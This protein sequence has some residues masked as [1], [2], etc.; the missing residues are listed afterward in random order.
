M[1]QAGWVACC[2]LAFIPAS[3][4]LADRVLLRGE[5]TSL[6]RD[7]GA[8][9][10]F[11]GT[12]L[13]R[14]VLGEAR[15]PEWRI[16]LQDGVRTF[17]VKGELSELKKTRIL[18]TQTKIAPFPGPGR[19]LLW[20]GDRLV[21]SE[22]L[23]WRTS[24]PDL[25]V[26]SYLSAT[27]TA[28]SYAEVRA[29]AAPFLED[30][31]LW[32]RVNSER[33]IANYYF[34]RSKYQE[35]EDAWRR[36]EQR[37]R[38]AGEPI[39]AERYTYARFLPKLLSCDLDGAQEVL[40]LIPE[41][42]LLRVGK[43]WR[44]FAQAQLASA[45][46]DLRTAEEMFESAAAEA[47]RSGEMKYYLDSVIEEASIFAE[48]GRWREAMVSLATLDKVSKRFPQDARTLALI[49]NLAGWIMLNAKQSGAMAL[50]MNRCQKNLIEASEHAKHAGAYDIL[51]H[52]TI[53]LALLYL[54]QGN[55]REARL[56]LERVRSDEVM[57]KS[58][59]GPFA[60]LALAEVELIEGHSAESMV[61][62]QK[63]SDKLATG[64]SSDRELRWRV[65]HMKGNAWA[66]SGA[67]SSAIEAYQKALEILRERS[68]YVPL[69]GGQFH[70]L[71]RRREPAVALIELL[72]AKGRNT[73]AFWIADELHSSVFQALDGAYKS[74]ER[75]VLRLKKGEAVLSLVQKDE[76]TWFAFLVDAGQTDVIL[77]AAPLA[78]LLPRL[79]NYSRLYVVSGGHEA[80]FHLPAAETATGEPLGAKL[81]ISLL[82]Y[83]SLLL[84]S[85]KREGPNLVVADPISNLDAARAE[86]EA[87]AEKIGGGMLVGRRA[88]RSAVRDR[89][90]KAGILHFAGHGVADA[91]RPW[92][93]HLKLSDGTLTL[94]DIL[95]DRPQIGLVVLASCKS[96]SDMEPTR[97]GLPQAFLHVG[98]NV[99]VASIRR[100]GD[101][102]ARRFV[103]QFYHH[104]G[105][106]DPFR[107]FRRVIENS[108]GDEAWKAFR[109]WGAKGGVESAPDKPIRIS[110]SQRT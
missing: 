71:W 25:E 26:Q 105:A 29:G 57:A 11:H 30:P 93:A 9:P 66:A 43:L 101:E 39:I 17:P 102:E 6:M 83:A 48:Q 7:G 45:R 37:A 21:S 99:V 20:C 46:G 4:R 110:G 103:Q 38:D 107:A 56:A 92:D 109:L 10:I 8:V 35:A 42:P 22:A 63:L 41:R 90:Q 81:E 34:G 23:E 54:S 61:L 104:G 3:A 24:P 100:V 59:A 108:K 88:S 74:A 75:G 76:K 53:N 91:S 28:A 87:V 78:E 73:D 13:P 1:K 33:A 32:V 47:E 16:E 18:H 49:H 2:A 82:P 97:I 44:V 58:T 55:V 36:A 70:A 19:A 96:G 15:C 106:E 67:T 60:L 85:E 62:L 12:R 65:E 64:C 68:T 69:D 98:S 31:E 27:S 77:S 52:V 72:R 40:S 5:D 94:K 80:A 84:S 79:Q 95:S 14:F 51:G 89:W 86:G 50:D